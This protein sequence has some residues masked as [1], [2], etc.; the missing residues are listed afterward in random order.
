VDQLA[1]TL[2]DLEKIPLVASPLSVAEVLSRL[3]KFRDD[4]DTEE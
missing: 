3:T 2:A 4:M 1:I